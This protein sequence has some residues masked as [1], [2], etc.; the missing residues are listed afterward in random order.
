MAL[1]SSPLINGMNCT[2][3][4][5]VSHCTVPR[6]VFIIL[7]FAVIAASVHDMHSAGTE[8]IMLN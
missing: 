3:M 8:L 5:Y 1:L 6:V 2:A 4:E 7:S